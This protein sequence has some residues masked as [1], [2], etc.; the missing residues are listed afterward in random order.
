MPCAGSRCASLDVWRNARSATCWG[1]RSRSRVDLRPLMTRERAA[2]RDHQHRREAVYSTTAFAVVMARSTTMLVVNAAKMGEI[3]LRYRDVTLRTWEE[4][5]DPCDDQE[6][7][8]RW[9][10]KP[11]GEFV[12]F[13]LTEW[14]FNTVP[15]E[16]AIKHAPACQFVVPN[17][18]KVPLGPTQAGKLSHKA[19]SPV[20]ERRFVVVEFDLRPSTGS[21]GFTGRRN[22][23]TRRGSTFTSLASSLS[24]MIV[25]SGNESAHGWYVT[26]WPRTLMTE[27]TSI[28]ADRALWSPSQFTR[29]PWGIHIN[30]TINGSCTS[31][32][33]DS[34]FMDSN[35]SSTSRGA[36]LEGDQAPRH[37][38]SNL[39]P[40]GETRQ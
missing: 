29:M 18:M 25:F 34:I 4:L 6:E 1:V 39:A 11:N 35:Y 30:G 40:T 37:Q 28:G 38:S 7:S 12:C 16:V 19:E 15:L 22:S 9:A 36:T 20:L 24:R 27:A 5:S 3:Q 33:T 26:K 14:K 32:A 8:L 13:G 31:P 2:A 10:F 23:I 17:P 21:T